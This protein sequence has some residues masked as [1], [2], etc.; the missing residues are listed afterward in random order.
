[1][2]ELLNDY[3]NY[4]DRNGKTER[5]IINHRTSVNRLVKFMEDYNPCHKGAHPSDTPQLRD[6][7]YTPK[8]NPGSSLVEVTEIDAK[9]FQDYMKANFKASTINQSLLHVRAFYDYLVEQKKVPDNPFS[10]QDLVT[11]QKKTPKWLS[12]LEQNRLIRTVRKHGNTKEL[13]II[14]LL[15]HTGLRVQELCDLRLQDIKLSD[16]KGTL[17]IQNGKLDRQRT[18]PLNKSAR[19]AITRYLE[20]YQPE[21]KYLFESQ[22]SSQ[23]NARAVQHIISKYKKITGLEHLTAHS[24]RH[25]YGHELVNNGVSLDKVA[26]VMGHMTKSG[27]PNIQQTIQYTRPGEDDLQ[28]AV[29]TSSWI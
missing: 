7:T 23:L 27:E 5:T 16:R 14:E 25:T 18:V 9:K 1:M 29:E 28:K 11:E 12:H 8:L 26:I 17:F 15:L 20:E 19:K 13:S 6:E 4:L 3:I 2:S 24:L 10:Q 22:R 21:G